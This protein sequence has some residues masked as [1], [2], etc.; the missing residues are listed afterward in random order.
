MGTEGTWSWEEEATCEEPEEAGQGQALEGGEGRDNTS[1][2]KHNE[3]RLLQLL[4]APPPPHTHTFAIPER[5]QA[6]CKAG[7][8]GRV[9]G[10]PTNPGLVNMPVFKVSSRQEA[11]TGGGGRTMPLI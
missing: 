1:S 11:G 9:P 5:S 2:V 3:A 10:L 8:Q 4:A 6:S 7:L